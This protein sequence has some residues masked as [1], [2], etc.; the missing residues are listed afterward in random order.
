MSFSIVYGQP[1]SWN[2]MFTFL[3]KVST[4]NLYNN[5]CCIAGKNKIEYNRIYLKKT[6]KDKQAGDCNVYC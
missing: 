5:F 2:Q 3:N 6:K 4:N 1:R